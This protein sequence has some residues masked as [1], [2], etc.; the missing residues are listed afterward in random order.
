[1][2]V[3]ASLLTITALPGMRDLYARYRVEADRQVFATLINTARHAAVNLNSTVTLCPGRDSTCGGRN[4]WHNGAFVFQ[5]LNKNRRR[6]EGEIIVAGINDLSSRVRWR[7]FRNRSALQFE[8]RGYTAW[9]NG[10]FIFCPVDQDPRF[11]RQLVLN[12]SGRLYF[13]RDR[14][15]DGYHEDVRGAPLAC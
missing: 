4:Q 7:A 9:Q 1:M 11:A 13:S 2:L 6:D 10:H 15:G 3:I 5:D 14:D 12:A 8:A